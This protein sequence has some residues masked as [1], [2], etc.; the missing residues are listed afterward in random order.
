[1]SPMRC[2]NAENIKQTQKQ[3]ITCA[4]QP[5]PRTRP[6]ALTEPDSS[7]QPVSW[8]P[9][10]LVILQQ[11]YD[12]FQPPIFARLPS[13][14]R[15]LVWA[16][17]LGG[18]LLHIVRVSKR[19]AATSCSERVHV[20]TEFALQTHRHGCWG[21]TSGPLGLR[22]T[23]SYYLHPQSNRPVKSVNFLPLLQTC[24]RIYAETI[25]TL[26]EDNI[27]DI[28][29]LDTILYLQRSV[30]PLRPNQIR[31]L[32]LTWEFKWPVAINPTPY[33]LATWCETCE[34]LAGLAG[35]QELSVYLKG[36]D[37]LPGTSRK[38]R[39]WSLLEALTLIKT[40]RKFCVFLPWSQDECLQTA[41]EDGW[42]FKLVSGIERPLQPHDDR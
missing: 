3:R 21:I 34:A 20:E 42:P 27:F 11:T 29:H 18:H 41:E 19:L 22:P 5:L 30:L 12:Q 28:N 36:M 16:E 10:K 2:G 23:P 6:R 38:E 25:S 31:V 9:F 39:R 13:E 33:N 4:P 1:M 15:R 14:V 8:S 37:L 17:S 32:N 26:Y 24:R 40:A 7:N 35:L